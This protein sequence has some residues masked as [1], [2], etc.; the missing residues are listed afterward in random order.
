MNVVYARK[1][2]FREV[3]LD[4]ETFFEKFIFNEINVVC[5]KKIDVVDNK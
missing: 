3:G 1:D 5:A 2:N 4:N